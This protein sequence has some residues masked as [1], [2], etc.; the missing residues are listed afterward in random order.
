M[1]VFIITLII[2][3]TIIVVVFLFYALF[4][5]K[6]EQN[7]QLEQ[8]NNFGQQG[9]NY[10]TNMLQILVKKYQ[11]SYVFDNFTFADESGHSINIDHIFVCCGGVFVIETKANKGQIIGKKDDTMWLAQKKS[12]QQNKAFRNPLKQNQR[13]INLLLRLLGPRP[14]RFISI[15]IFPNAD[16]LK[17]VQSSMVF[18]V[19]S[20]HDYLEN[21]ILKHTYNGDM[22]ESMYRQLYLLK[23]RY[24]IT[25]DEHIKNMQKVHK[26]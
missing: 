19:A 18:N 15:V 4:K 10:V 23:G 25:L 11:P 8:S 22:V 1:K 3:S 17:D 12:W 14:M 13:H 6:H 16:S 7:K 21:E 5:K 2:I 20:A 9:E 24:G 26:S